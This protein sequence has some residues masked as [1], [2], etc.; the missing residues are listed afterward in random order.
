[1]EGQLPSGCLVC[2]FYTGHSRSGM[3]FLQDAGAAVS[4]RGPPD[5]GFDSARHDSCHHR[6]FWGWAGIHDAYI[7]HPGTMRHCRYGVLFVDVVFFPFS[8]DHL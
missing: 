6:Q 7:G 2:A 1:M 3:G 5:P 4:C 8:G